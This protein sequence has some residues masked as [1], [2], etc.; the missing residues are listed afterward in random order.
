MDESVDERVAC[1]VAD[2]HTAIAAWLTGSAP[3][4]P[5]AFAAFTDAHAPG[6]GMITPDGAFV[7]RDPLFHGFEGAHGSA[8][9]LAIRIDDVQVV[10]ADAGGIVAIYKEWQDGPDGHTER[11][12]TVVLDHEPTAPRGLRALHLHETWIT[13]ER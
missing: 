4:T 7:A 1:W 5:P 9:G 11:R 6:F 13:R 12:S 8:P 10:R 3:R 2:L